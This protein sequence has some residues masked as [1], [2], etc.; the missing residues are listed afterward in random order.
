M[1]MKTMPSVPPFPDRSPTF[2]GNA[3]CT[4]SP[5]PLSLGT[6]NGNGAP[7]EHHSTQSVTPRER[8]PETATPT[9]PDTGQE[10]RWADRPRPC[11]HCGRLAMALDDQDRPAHAG[12]AERDRRLSESRGPH[13]V[14]RSRVDRMTITG[15]R[16]GVA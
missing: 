12:C 16:Q 11:V 8:Q 4:R 13:G 1:I 10:I 9:S 3:E 2:P 14:D 5:V 15:A 6:G 7:Q